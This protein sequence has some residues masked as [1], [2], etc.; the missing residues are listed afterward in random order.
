M[1]ESSS[2]QQQ[3]SFHGIGEYELVSLREE[4]E[5]LRR[6]NGRYKEEVFDLKAVAMMQQEEAK[7]EAN[8][9]VSKQ[10]TRK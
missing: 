9:R 7:T 6:D 10:Q 1:L 3:A 4:V 2:A 8:Q 5:R